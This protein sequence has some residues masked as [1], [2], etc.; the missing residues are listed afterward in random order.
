MKRVILV[1]ISMVLALSATT[2]VAAESK[3]IVL[4]AGPPSHGPGEHEHRAGCL[5]LKSCLDKVSGISAT[6]YSNG[7]PE[8]PDTAFSGASTVLIYSDGGGGHPFL[9]DD[10]LQ[11]IGDLM[12]KGVGLVCIHY[13]VEP[14]KERGEKEFLD[15]M[16]GC[17]EINRSVNPTWLADFKTLP[18]H[19]IASGVK[20]F[21]IRDEWYFFM[22]FCDGMQG[23]T[24]ILTAVAPE[25]TMARR[26]GPHEGNPEV[27]ASV[28]RG[29][30]QH[31]AWAF[32][33]P[34]GGRGFG[35]T[36][37]HY[38]KNWGND[39][40]RKLVLNAILWTAKVGVPAEGVQSTV[41]E[42][43]LKANLDPKGK[44]R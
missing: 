35:F 25:S 17:F 5:L 40:F 12:K 43:D 41:T 22:R 3:K 8:N 36:G 16:G 29:E 10:R 39:N 33:R 20:P 37:A 6:V 27:R 26:D 15:W 9:Q 44:A 7:W 13:A 2:L 24:P 1:L 28:E 32:E 4:I 23:V 34:D 21:S 31:M 38:H 11:T 14:T 18:Q 42:D 30:P 19:P